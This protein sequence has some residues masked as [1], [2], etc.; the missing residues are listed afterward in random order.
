[1]VFLAHLEH[2]CLAVISGYL[3]PHRSVLSVTKK[4]IRQSD[5]EK[6]NTTINIFLRRKRVR[7]PSVNFRRYFV[8]FTRF[9]FLFVAAG[10][11]K[12]W[13]IKMRS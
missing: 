1:V 9:L 12:P 10:Q 13:S 2:I 3:S 5:D 6:K 11:S 8:C 7:L 4:E